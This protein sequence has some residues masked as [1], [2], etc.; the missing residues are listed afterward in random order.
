[1]EKKNN[2]MRNSI[3]KKAPLAEWL[4]T[5]VDHTGITQSIAPPIPAMTRAHVIQAMVYAEACSRA[6]SKAQREPKTTASMRPH[7]SAREPATRAPIRVRAY[8]IPR[9]NTTFGG[10]VP[11]VTC[12]EVSLAAWI[13]LHVCYTGHRIYAHSCLVIWIQIDLWHDT[14]VVTIEHDGISYRILNISSCELSYACQ[15]SSP[16]NKFIAVYIDLG[17]LNFSILLCV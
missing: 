3:A 16:A 11:W 6:P 9:N 12:W 7:R 10:N 14:L 13:S 17:F 1:M 15:K 5:S 8:L 4:L 2:I